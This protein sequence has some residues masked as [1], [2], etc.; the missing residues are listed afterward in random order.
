[1]S[2]FT[3]MYDK[4]AKP[5]SGFEPIPAGQYLVKIIESE[6]KATKAGTGEYLKLMFEVCDGN[7]KGRK[8]TEILNLRNPSAKAV[9]IAQGTFA[10]IRLAT[11][12]HEPRV[13]EELHDIPMIAKIT[14]KDDTNQNGEP[15][16]RNQIKNFKPRGSAPV[17]EQATAQ[18]GSAEQHIDNATEALG[19]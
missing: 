17:A 16:V 5:S 15:I 14:Q 8:V 6:I 2:S 13:P 10:A 4:D 11:G 9:E 19:L 18:E 12:V 7:Y 1:M 3:D